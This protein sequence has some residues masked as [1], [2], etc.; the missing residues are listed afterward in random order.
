MKNALIN[1]LL[2]L[3]LSGYLQEGTCQITQFKLED[4]KPGSTTS[5]IP[6]F[7][8]DELIEITIS[9]DLRTLVFDV[10]DE[11]D[12]HKGT[13]SYLN[14]ADTINQ[15]ISIKT[16]GNYRR[17][18]ST[19]TFPPLRINF[20]KDTLPGML[21]SGMKDVKLVTH[22]QDRKVHT[23]YVL[24]E[25]LIYRILNQFTDLS[26][27][28]RLVRVTY[29]DTKDRVKPTEQYGFFIEPTS[30]MAKRNGGREIELKGL[31]LNHVNHPIINLFTVFQ[32]FIANTDWSIHALHNVKL[33]SFSSEP[34]AI[35]VPYDFDFSGTI[36]TYY[37]L[38]DS[39]LRIPSVRVRLFR[40]NCRKLE[41]LQATF[42]LF[43]EKKEQVYDL[44]R[45]FPYLEEKKIKRILKYYDDFYETLDN[46]KAAQR[47][48]ERCPKKKDKT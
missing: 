1:I 7:T 41:E 30:K 23:D 16:R 34:M 37:A 36:Y 38:P 26:Y 3:I 15:Q 28:V 39:A 17:D 2:V 6:L 14:G 35:P 10:G 29:L 45:N 44:Y 42:N 18:R 9:T 47:A 46:P 19:C 43:R 32:Y 11:R 8:R 12:S 33:V 22:C 27:K 21:F 40:S 24:E 31:A 48:F 20:N 4:Y 25:Y 5:E 13:L